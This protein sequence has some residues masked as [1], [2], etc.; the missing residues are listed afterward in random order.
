MYQI[1]QIAALLQ[2]DPAG[3]VRQCDASYDA[4]LE[5]AAQILARHRSLSP[6]VLL[7]GP[8]ASGKTG[9][10]QWLRSKL[11]RL[12]IRAYQVSMADYL[13][14]IEPDSSPRNIKGEIDYESPFCMDLDLL[15]RHIS[16]LEQG[17]TVHIPHFDIKTHCRSLSRTTELCLHRDELVIFEGLHA[18]NDYIA[19]KNPKALKLF[20]HLSTDLV[21]REVELL[22]PQ[23]R[24][25]RR[26]VRDT[27]CRGLDP[28]FTM[29][30]WHNVRRGEKL[31]SA[32]FAD[33]ADLVLDSFIPY[34]AAVL[35]PL[36]EPILQRLS[37]HWGADVDP[38]LQALSHFQPLDTRYLTDESP[39]WE[40]IP[41]RTC[42]DTTN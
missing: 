30:L 39:V 34:E 20:I 21:D 29:Q 19:G 18:L 24:F 40:F 42:A 14:N 10:A 35:K 17:Q 12:G 16:M 6:I 3:F 9:A 4:Q 27:L 2:S 15:N 13:L 41:P 23:V 1:P 32:P 8:S 38:I 26:M 22:R 5:K 25:C 33:N 36:A 11:E 37:L 7:S 31:Y 28:D